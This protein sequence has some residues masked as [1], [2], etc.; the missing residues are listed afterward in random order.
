MKVSILPQDT[1]M[2]PTKISINK[3]Q[4][5][6][7]TDLISRVVQYLDNRSSKKDW[8]RSIPIRKMNVL[9]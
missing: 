4:Y 6:K 1:Q 9:P 8:R 3:F 5:T 2:L 7:V